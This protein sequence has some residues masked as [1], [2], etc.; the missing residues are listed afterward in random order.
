MFTFLGLSIH[1]VPLI[2]ISLFD[3][4]CLYRGLPSSQARAGKALK[5]EILSATQT[6]V[7]TMT[8][9]EH[10]DIPA[11]QHDGASMC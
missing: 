3:D 1:Y 5:C 4:M 7:Q 8:T 11:H 10:S 2:L 9:H 6:F